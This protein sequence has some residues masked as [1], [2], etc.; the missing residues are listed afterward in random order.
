HIV[1][2]GW[3]MG[4]LTREIAVLYEAFS[5]GQESPL[6]EL[7]I[8]YAD[9]AVWQ[10]ERLQ[11]EVLEREINYWK[12]QLSEVPPALELPTDHPRPPVRS[13]R[14][15]SA[16]LAVPEEVTRG[17]KELSRQEGATLF[18]VL[19]AAWQVL[20]FR[21]SGQEDIVVGTPIAGRV[22]EETE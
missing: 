4:V 15:A 17:L 8:Q 11:G 7:K 2:D 14:G 5:Q 16:G 1:S 12:K 6:E 18:A 22:R 21:Y 9:Y 13:G 20:L 19:L 10:R 3:S